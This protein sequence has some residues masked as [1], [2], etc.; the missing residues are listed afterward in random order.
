MDRLGLESPGLMGVSFGGVLALEFATR[1]PHR[2][3]RLLIQGAGA[4][5][6][7]GLLEQ[8]AGITLFMQPVQDISVEDRV[9]RTE[10]QY[11]LEDASSEELNR[12]APQMTIRRRFV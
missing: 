3:D 5:F 8:V 1:Y 2:L 11:T 9:S 10:F 7:P 6:E 12:L 4:R